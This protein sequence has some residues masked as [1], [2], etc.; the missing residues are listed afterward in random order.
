MFV[1]GGGFSSAERGVEG[2]VCIGGKE[3]AGGCDKKG[4]VVKREGGSVSI[5]SDFK[6]VN[7]YPTYYYTGGIYSQ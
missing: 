1:V 6:M 2:V 3:K 4:E 5:C 7:C